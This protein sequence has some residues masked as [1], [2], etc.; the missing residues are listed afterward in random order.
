MQFQP[1]DRLPILEWAAWWDQTIDR[2]HREGLPAHLSDQCDIG[3]HFGLD[4]HR[5]DWFGARSAECPQ[6]ASYG[7]GIIASEEDY[8]RIR[9]CLYP[10]NSVDHDKWQRWADEQ[11]RGDVVLWFTLEGFFWYPRT[12]L[13][14][15]RD[16]YAYYD[17]PDLMHRMNTDLTQWLLLVIDEVC[18]ICTPDFMTFAEDMSY[19]HGPMLSKDLFDE[20]MKPY[21]LAVVPKLNEHNVISMIDSDGDVSVPMNVVYNHHFEAPDEPYA[22]PSLTRTQT[23]SV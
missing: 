4:I 11:R 7:A 17:Q 1:F 22:N 12:L 5:Q 18:S 15:E 10:S 3:R 14:I 19:N 16:F 20:F 13:G 8:D 23:F 6:P 21:Y 9:P 2:W